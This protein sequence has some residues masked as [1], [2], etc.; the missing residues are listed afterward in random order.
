MR[1]SLI[2]IAMATF[3]LSS[4]GPSPEEKLNNLSHWDKL[5]MPNAKTNF[6]KVMSTGNALWATTYGTGKIFSRDNAGNTW[7]ENASLGC[8][9]IEQVQ[10]V[11]NNTGYLCG[12][13]GY[14]YKTIDGGV[15]WN[16]IGPALTDRIVEKFR[17][18]KTKNQKP[19]G[20]FVAFTDMFFENAQ[21]GYIWGF[22][23][24]PSV[25]YNE[26]Y[27][28]I[29]YTTQDGGKNWTLIAKNQIGKITSGFYKRATKNKIT[30]GGSKY[31]LDNNNIWRTKTVKGKGLQMEHSKDAG[32]TWVTSPA[33]KYDGR[34]K[35]Q[36]TL[37]TDANQGYIFGTTTDKS[38]KAV[39]FQSKDSGATWT[40]MDNKWAPIN[41]AVIHNNEIIIATQKGGLYTSPT[42]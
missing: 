10:F 37:F 4:C 8:E 3:L 9:Y 36:K 12:D 21:S 17:E 18:D 26:T 22:Y 28:N 23:Y 13:Y 25:G 34:W 39:V 14:V 6:Y 41:D 29:C 31:Y 20:W 33:P 40:Q 16:D 38:N 15:S 35:I 32:L 42:F 11:N 1:A 7:T 19:K 2:L 27:D 30:L 24:D 5:N